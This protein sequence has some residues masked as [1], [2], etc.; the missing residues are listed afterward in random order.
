MLVPTTHAD[1]KKE[2]NNRERKYDLDADTQRNYAE[3]GVRFYLL[4]IMRV[5]GPQDEDLLPGPRKL[6]ALL[7]YLCLTEEARTSRSRVVN[8]LWSDSA[9]QQAASS[10]R[11]GLWQLSRLLSHHIPGL[12]QVDRDA[13]RLD[14]SRCWI[15]VRETLE[16][17][18]RLLEG[19]DGLTIPFDGWLREERAAL[20]NRA[21]LVLEQTLQRLIDEGASPDTRATAARRL[22]NFEPTHEGALRALMAAFH[23]MGEPAQAIRE[24]ERFQRA[25]RSADLPI[26]AQTIT[27]YESIRLIATNRPRKQFAIPE[28]RRSSAAFGDRQSQP[29]EDRASIAVLPFGSVSNLGRYDYAAAGIEDQLV[30]G[31]SRV[32][33]LFVI[34]RMSTMPFRREARTPRELG[35]VL[36]VR[37][38]VSGRMG[39][40]GDDIGIQAEL[41]DTQRT[42]PIWSW[43]TEERHFDWG[44]VNERLI[45]SIVRRVAP[46]GRGQVPGRSQNP[47]PEAYDLF[48]RAQ[49]NMHN[50]SQVVFSTCEELLDAALALEPNY[51]S[52]LAW[53]AR[54]HLLRIAQGWSRSPERDAEWA[55][56]FA[57]RAVQCDRSEPM[58]LAVHAYL[59]AYL[60]R[61]FDLALRRFEKAL[62]TNPNSAQAWFWSAT[63]SAW[64]GDGPRCIEQISRTL[65]LS[66]YDPLTHAYN[67]TAAL[68]YFVN[69]EYQRAI[70]HALRAIY[71]NRS[72]LIGYVVL[73]MSLALCGFHAEAARAVADL[74]KLDPNFTVTR[75]R[76]RSPA[77]SGPKGDLFCDALMRAG[78]PISD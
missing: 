51:A 46:W 9:D 12:I 77:C 60:H 39:V 32:P 44:E 48:L 34:S 41:N 58:A 29:Q 42:G 38:V 31:L 72:H 10:L 73:A 55:E 43:S 21:R 4:G 61:D 6:R 40:L 13:I 17:G 14:K 54:W 3:C 19:F 78:V 69:D 5:H 76:E 16:R 1:G 35:D 59:A 15:D 45:D 63:V 64:L 62:A 53:R 65:A 70:E 47:C 20:E 52:A 24:F 27:L 36:G 25:M 67:T 57:K 50:S 23:D 22:V 75:F 71:E 68:G 33:N 37:Y 8:L 7:A 74:R 26:S 49:E 11:H 56:N 18:D 30:E 2:S 66:P 28:P